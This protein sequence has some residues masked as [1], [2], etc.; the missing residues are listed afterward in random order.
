VARS[1]SFKSDRYHFEPRGAFLKD[2]SLCFI[3]QGN[4]V[5]PLI[6]AEADR[7]AAGQ[8]GERV[9][10]RNQLLIDLNVIRFQGGHGDDAGES[11]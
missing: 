5:Q 7:L 6:A 3:A 11:F 4:L 8:S 10:G 2:E 1:I 9:K